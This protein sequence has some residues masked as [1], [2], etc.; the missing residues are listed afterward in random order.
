MK[1]RLRIGSREA[2]AVLRERDEPARRRARDRARVKVK[3]R[4][5]AGAADQADDASQLADAGT[6]VTFDRHGQPDQ[7][8][9]AQPWAQ[10]VQVDIPSRG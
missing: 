1:L 8:L 6:P 5:D 10:T 9:R 2:Q 3:D 4:I 7:Q